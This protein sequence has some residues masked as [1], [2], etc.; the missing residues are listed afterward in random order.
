MEKVIKLRNL[1]LIYQTSFHNGTILAS[2]KELEEKFGI[3]ATFVNDDKVYFELDLEV[4]G[5]PFT[6]YDWKE[7][8]FTKDTQVWLHIGT[9]TPED[10][11]KV[12]EVL[13]NDYDLTAKYESYE[14]RRARLGL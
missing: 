13:K 2:I 4:G 6:I 11:K 12:V 14:E 10:T 9:R 7:G 3:K 1:D 8:Y 5:I